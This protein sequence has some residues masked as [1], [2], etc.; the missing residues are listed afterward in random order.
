MLFDFNFNAE[1]IVVIVKF[2]STLF[3]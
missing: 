3:L 1:V 2:I